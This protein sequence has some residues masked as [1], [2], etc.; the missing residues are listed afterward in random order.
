MV[1]K[2]PPLPPA[3]PSRGAGPGDRK[4]GPPPGVKGP[5]FGDILDEARARQEKP[6]FSAHARERLENRRI[7]L[8]EGDL[9]KIAR[10]MEKA[11]QKGARSALLI[12]G[13]VAMVASVTNRTVITAVDMAEQ[14]E[15][16]F[17][18]IDSAVIFK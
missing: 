5:S 12:Y 6:L 18:G 11:G 14:G 9:E 13:G 8:H 17:T 3:D 7:V 2:T 15:Q 4:T 1:S 10:A 16:V